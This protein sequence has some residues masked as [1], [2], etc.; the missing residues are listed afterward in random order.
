MA[1]STIK[2]DSDGNP[3]RAKYR[4]V[5]LGNMDPINWS[6]SECY[7]PVLSLA[8]LRLLTSLAV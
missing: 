4:I 2:Y 5:A 7:A 6:K 8:E 3:L 1:I